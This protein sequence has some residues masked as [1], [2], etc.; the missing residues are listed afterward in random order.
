MAQNE[1]SQTSENTQPRSRPGAIQSPPPIPAKSPNR[2]LLKVRDLAQ[3]PAQNKT[4]S[5]LP[6]QVKI[7]S[8]LYAPNHQ[9]QQSRALKRKSSDVHA[10]SDKENNEPENSVAA[11][12]SNSETD[13]FVFTS[14][15]VN[16]TV[17]KNLK[18]A[19]THTTA[20][21]A[22]AGAKRA[23]SRATS[24]QAK[25]STKVN[26]VLSPRS[27]NSRTLPRS[28]IKDMPPP[29]S[30]T[31]GIPQIRPPSPSK[32]LSPFRFAANAATSALSSLAKAGSRLARPLSRDKETQIL[33]LATTSNVNLMQSVGTSPSGKMLPPQRPITT[34]GHLTA[35]QTAGTAASP[36][37]TTSQTSIRSA[38]TD[39]SITSGSTVIT[40]SKG[41]STSRS[42]AVARKPMANSARVPSSAV[43]ASPG[44]VGRAGTIQPAKS[45]A[46]NASEARSKA[47]L[48]PKTTN[49][50]V[51][52]STA[53]RVGTTVKR[54]MTTKKAETTVAG[55][56][57]ILRKRT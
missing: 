53:A 34:I 6:D 2:N 15:A 37:R 38:T 10:I 8:D 26:G 3:P 18:R 45:A 47:V 32:P 40:K 30:P 52:K 12:I 28:P 41:S 16:L 9:Q 29:L 20:P 1:S 13:A 42:T 50:G 46:T 55:T 5:S 31:H 43:T 27:Y 21:T 57:R 24:K 44:K 19:K 56:G 11:S 23:P 25:A 35:A 49:A 36:Q 51:K 14:G 39:Q 48:S 4:V 17:Q 22:S 54:A 7:R 33:S